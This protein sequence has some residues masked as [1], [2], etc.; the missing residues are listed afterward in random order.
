MSDN[1]KSEWND[2]VDQ[3][4]KAGKV[5]GKLLGPSSTPKQQQKAA[6]QASAAIVKMTPSIAPIVAGIVMAPILSVYA[7]A[8]HLCYFDFGA[9]ARLGSRLAALLAPFY[10]LGLSFFFE[11][12]IPFTTWATV[13]GSGVLVVAGYV[14]Y[15]VVR[16]VGGEDAEFIGHPWI[17]LVL[18]AKLKSQR[19]LIHVVMT[20]VLYGLF[21]GLLFFMLFG[22]GDFGLGLGLTFGLVG[23]IGWAVTMSIALGRLALQERN[24][25]PHQEAATVQET[26]SEVHTVTERPFGILGVYHDLDEA[27]GRYMDAN[28]RSDIH[29]FVQEYEVTIQRPAFSRRV[30]DLAFCCSEM[31]DGQT[32]FATWLGAKFTEDEL[33]RIYHADSVFKGDGVDP[34]VTADAKLEAMMPA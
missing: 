19:W 13:I 18:P 28:P 22:A 26:V 30:V 9:K 24:A 11:D 3:V 5:M 34:L 33:H 20:P 4:A 15:S 16:K 29:G 27:C 8:H 12:L 21:S 7:A 1:G 17:G 10:V 25:A 14:V 23:G 6:G 32:P 2:T 31:S